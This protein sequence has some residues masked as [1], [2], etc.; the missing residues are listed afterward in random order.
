MYQWRRTRARK[1]GDVDS[2]FLSSW[3][4]TKSESRPVS[5]P[6]RAI[7]RCRGRTDGLGLGRVLDSRDSASFSDRCD[8]SCS[9]W[10]IISEATASSRRCGRAVVEFVGFWLGRVVGAKLCVS[11]ECVEALEGSIPTLGCSRRCAGAAECRRNLQPFARLWDFADVPAPLWAGFEAS[12]K[13][14]REDFANVRLT[15]PA[16]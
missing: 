9:L 10:R 1:R 14:A 2:A 13:P 8:A 15:S 7:R 4:A 12:P 11:I 16:R 3:S 5:P 6:A